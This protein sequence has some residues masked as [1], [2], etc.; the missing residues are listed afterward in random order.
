MCKDHTVLTVS[1]NQHY[2]QLTL[3][4]STISWVWWSLVM[5]FT[6]Q[7]HYLRFIWMVP[8]LI[9]CKQLV[10]KG[11]TFMFIRTHIESSS[12][13]TL[14]HVYLCH[15]VWY[16]RSTGFYIFQTMHLR[17]ILVDNELHAQFCLRYVYLNPLHVL[18]N[19]VLILRKTTVLIQH[20]V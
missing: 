19:Y 8:C 11:F 17:I 5:P 2:F 1:H 18:S 12:L 9:H 14:P 3:F 15:S 16:A 10:K 7:S 20:L 4:Q 13:H 6:W